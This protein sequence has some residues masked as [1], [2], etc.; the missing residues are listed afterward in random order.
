MNELGAI[1]I[2]NG[3]KTE[4]LWTPNAKCAIDMAIKALENRRKIQGQWLIN[5]DGYYPYCSICKN[6]PQNRV[7][8]KYCPNCGAY[9]K[10]E[11][12]DDRK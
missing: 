9:M 7:M 3:V 2:L 12:E 6:E 8:T 1:T 4:D 10:A 11:A 5:S